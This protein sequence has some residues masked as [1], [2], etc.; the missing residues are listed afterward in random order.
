[1]A[2]PKKEVSTMASSVVPI[3]AAKVTKPKAT[4]KAASKA[5]PNIFTLRVELAESVPSI[6]RQIEI[7]SRATL[8]VLHHVLQAAMGW[9]DSHLHE[10]EIAGK[11]YADPEDDEYGDFPDTL[12]ESLFT[13]KDLVKKGKTF[14]YLY[15]FGDGWRHNITVNATSPA[16]RSICDVGNAWI[17]DGQRAC[18][19]EDCGGIWSYQDFLKDDA[20]ELNGDEA[21]EFREWAGLD[22]DPERFDRKAANA[23]IARMFWNHWIVIGGVKQ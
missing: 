4:S 18:P 10:F 12:D 2:V 14:A 8:E 22:F 7:D 20:D 3:P 11:R 13:L 5:V 23:A 15:D 6:W 16:H 21:L 19:P 9:T 1:M 17:E